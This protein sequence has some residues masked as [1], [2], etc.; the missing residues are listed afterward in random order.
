MLLTPLPLA[1][2]GHL[3]EAIPFFAPVLVLALVLAGVVLR[4]RWSARMPGHPAL[5][6]ERPGRS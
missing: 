1:H 2:A 5:D 4:D 6:P 3:I